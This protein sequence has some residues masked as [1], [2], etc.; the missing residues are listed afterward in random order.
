MLQ[1]NRI[2]QWAEPA[3]II[4]T[5]AIMGI[6]ASDTSING[7]IVVDSISDDIEKALRPRTVLLSGPS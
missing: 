5:R 7:V 6:F 3:E 4:D 2:Y 1:V